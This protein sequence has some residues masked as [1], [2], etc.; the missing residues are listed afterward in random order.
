MDD[1]WQQRFTTLSLDPSNLQTF[2]LSH[3]AFVRNRC[4]SKE[5]IIGKDPNTRLPLDLLRRRAAALNGKKMSF[6]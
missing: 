6:S 5:K 4:G 3:F 2:K 1:D